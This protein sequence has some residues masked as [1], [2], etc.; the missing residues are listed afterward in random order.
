MLEDV[1]YFPKKISPFLIK[2]TSPC[3]LKTTSL[4]HVEPHFNKTEKE[5]GKGPKALDSNVN[6]C[7]A[8]VREAEDNKQLMINTILYKIKLILYKRS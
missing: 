7:E 6:Q 1:V 8:F 4:Y 2:A 3:L 5:K